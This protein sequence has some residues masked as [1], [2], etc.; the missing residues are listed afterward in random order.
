M[1][2]FGKWKG[3]ICDLELW[4]GEGLG[5]DME[6]IVLDIDVKIEVGIVG[7]GIVDGFWVVFS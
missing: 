7:E 4:L 1:F 6:G 2:R 3:V 5:E